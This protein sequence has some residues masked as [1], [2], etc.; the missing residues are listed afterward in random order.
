MAEG[1][2]PEERSIDT[3]YV[4]ITFTLFYVC[5]LDTTLLLYYL[6]HG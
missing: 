6:L 4:H 3:K 2:I 1:K 5:I